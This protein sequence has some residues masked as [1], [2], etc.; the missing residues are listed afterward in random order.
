MFAVPTTTRNHEV[1]EGGGAERATGKEMLIRGKEEQDIKGANRTAIDDIGV[2]AAAGPIG[3]GPQG[4]MLLTPEKIAVVK[5]MGGK[6]EQALKGA[7]D[8]TTV[9]IRKEEFIASRQRMKA[10]KDVPVIDGKAVLPGK[11][12]EVRFLF[13]R[14]NIFMISLSETKV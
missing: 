3:S 8:G 14:C 6:E 12:A 7:A 2:M 10:G 11:K 1:E 9:Q 4:G 13:P 5:E